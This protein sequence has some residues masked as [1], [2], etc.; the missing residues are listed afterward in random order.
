MTTYTA[1]TFTCPET[2]DTIMEIPQDLLEKMNWGVGTEVKFRVEPTGEVTMTR[3][4]PLRKFA[5]ETVSTF[6]HVYIV[7]CESAEHAMDAVACNEVEGY[8]QKHAG[9][10]ILYARQVDNPDIV[11]LYQET[12]D[13]NMTLE[14]LESR[15]YLNIVHK[16]D[17]SK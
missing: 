5:V 16:I 9:E 10:H 17:Y 11:T 8:L 13:E 12:E 2:G 15:H 7:E 14:K 1:N 3:A 4:K 6:R